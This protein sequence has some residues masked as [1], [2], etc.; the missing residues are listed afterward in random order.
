MSEELKNEDEVNETIEIKATEN[1]KHQSPQ[2]PGKSPKWPSFPNAHQFWKW[3]NF[4]NNS[5]NKQR[6]WRSAWR[7]R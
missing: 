4:F 5:F 3:N 7:W 6:Q 2:I 1:H